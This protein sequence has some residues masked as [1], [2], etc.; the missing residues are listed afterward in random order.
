M[1]PG[2]NIDQLTGLRAVAAWAV[3]IYH[4]RLFMDEWMPAWFIDLFYYGDLAVDL[5]FILSGFVLYLNYSERLSNPSRAQW[6][7]FISKRFARIYPLHFVLMMAYL[8]VPFLI[9]TFGSSGELPDKFSPADFFLSL[10]LIHN[11]GFSDQLSWNVP[12][13]SIS[14]EWLAYLIFPALAFLLTRRKIRWEMAALLILVTATLFAGYY[15]MM[16]YEHLPAVIMETGAIRCVVSFFIGNL[17]SIIFVELKRVGVRQGVFWMFVGSF[18]LVVSGA[19]FQIPTYVTIPT[20]FAL[21]I[22]A[23][24]LDQS[25]LQRFLARKVMV[26]L[27]NISYATYLVHYLIYD[28][29]KLV[30][31]SDQGTAAPWSVF[32][33][34]AVILAASSFLYHMVELPAQ[35]F[36][37]RKARAWGERFK[38]T[39]PPEGVVSPTRET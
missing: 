35:T 32:L 8:S 3:V 37:N 4:F 18:T 31:A 14:A 23:V 21:L 6:F 15:A 13:W 20:A 16:G 33:A 7:A 26:Y 11:W 19:L 22:L 2:T 24:A 10:A 17:L 30:F 34:F 38:K 1:K 12:S 9:L 39:V 27:G 5:F 36:I 28:Y 25:A 29:F